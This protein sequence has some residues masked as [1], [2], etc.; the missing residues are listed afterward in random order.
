MGLN[1]FGLKEQ[2]KIDMDLW[3][4]EG[5]PIRPDFLSTIYNSSQI[6][7]I[8]GQKYSDREVRLAREFFGSEF[9]VLRLFQNNYRPFLCYKNWKNSVLFRNGDYFDCPQEEVKV[10]AWQRPAKFPTFV[11]MWG[12]R[13]LDSAQWAASN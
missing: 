10:L 8:G 9:P 4:G 2:V 11:P 3:R 12:R 13:A 6:E 5:C 7:Y 1:S